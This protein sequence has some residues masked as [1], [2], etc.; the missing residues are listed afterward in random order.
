MR[1]KNYIHLFIDFL[2]FFS[3]FF[4]INVLFDNFELIYVP[5]QFPKISE[6]CCCSVVRWIKATLS[7]EQK[8]LLSVVLF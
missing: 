2:F 1:T 7:F 8:A 3:F 5:V 6:G 4:L